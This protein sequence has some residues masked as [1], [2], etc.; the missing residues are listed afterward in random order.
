MMFQRNKLA[1]ANLQASL[2]VYGSLGGFSVFLF[3]FLILSKIAS[4]AFFHKSW[5]SWYWKVSKGQKRQVCLPSGAPLPHLPADLDRK[6]GGKRLALKPTDIWK[7]RCGPPPWQDS[8]RQSCDKPKLDGE[9]PLTVWTGGWICHCLARA[10]VCVK[11]WHRMP[12]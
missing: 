1:W 9:T 11:C 3:C 10:A 8:A 7:H 4:N 12:E 6:G 5:T 2:F